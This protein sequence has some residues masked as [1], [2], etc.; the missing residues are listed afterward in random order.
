MYAR[1]VVDS[2]WLHVPVN[3]FRTYMF[4]ENHT[5]ALSPNTD[6]AKFFLYAGVADFDEN[7]ICCEFNGTNPL[8][9]SL[10]SVWSCRT[11]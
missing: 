5:I 2:H 3:R 8:F 4:P 9:C 1:S 11:T 6:K 10:Y 7:T